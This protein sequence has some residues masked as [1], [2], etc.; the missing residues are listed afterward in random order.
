MKTLISSLVFVAVSSSAAFANGIPV[1]SSPFLGNDSITTSTGSSCSQ[2]LSTGKH[3]E[4]GGYK[5]EST[6]E[7]VVYGRVV[8]ALGTSSV[9]RINCNIM[10]DQERRRQELQL[11]KLELEVELLERQAKEREN[12]TST[13]I[14]DDW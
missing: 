10:Y 6:G 7:G 12:F 2:S 14:G 1:S 11:R 5:D 13:E 9:K 3:F 8:I 4:A